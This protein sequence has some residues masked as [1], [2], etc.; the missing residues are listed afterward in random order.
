VKL[1]NK[2]IV[3][4]YAALEYLSGERLNQATALQ[5]MRMK[6]ALKPHQ[7]DVAAANDAIVKELGLKQGDGPEHPR[8]AEFEARRKE[9]YAIEL[10]VE[11]P[12]LKVSQLWARNYNTGERELMDVP[13]RSL[14][15][16]GELLV[17][18]DGAGAST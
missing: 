12:T 4:A 9:L 8:F 13:A 2:Q 16:L 14:D 10:D 1:S 6:R 3:D 17:L 7:E 15:K 5:V 11:V 18:D